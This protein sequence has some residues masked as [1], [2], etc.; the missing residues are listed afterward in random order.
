MTTVHPSRLSRLIMAEPPCHHPA[1]PRYCPQCKKL[2]E[3]FNITARCGW[4]GQL[5][6]SMMEGDNGAYCDTCHTIYLAKE[7]TGPREIMEAAV[8]ASCCFWPSDKIRWVD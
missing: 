7:T 5:P 8:R 6:H 1:W 3:G 4:Y 2:A